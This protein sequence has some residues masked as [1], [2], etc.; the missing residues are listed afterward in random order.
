MRIV[1]PGTI[2]E[3]SLLTPKKTNYLCSVDANHS[4]KNSSISHVSIAWVDIS[5]SQCHF[6]TIPCGSLESELSRLAPTEILIS[7][8]LFSIPKVKSHVGSFMDC[9]STRAASMFNTKKCEEIIKTFFSTTNTTTLGEITDSE[10]KAIGSLIEYLSHTHK[11]SLPKLS[12][13]RRVSADHFMNIDASTRSSLELTKNLAGNN[14]H[15]LLSAIDTT[16]TAAGGRLLLSHIT[17]PLCN[18]EAINNRLDALEFFIQHGELRKKV[19]ELLKEFTDIERAVARVCIFK[20]TLK[21][22]DTIR[23]GLRSANK[24]ISI[25]TNDN[26]DYMPSNLKAAILQ[27]TTPTQVMEQLTKALA[28]ELP[29]HVK[30]GDFVRRKFSSELDRLYDIKMN[31]DNKVESLCHKYKSVSGISNLKINHN[32]VIGYYIEVKPNMAE[33][34]DESVFIHRQTLGTSMRFVSDELKNLE[35]E[36]IKC[37]DNISNLENEIFHT[38]CSRV[39][40]ESSSIQI[41]SLGVASIDLSTSLAELAVRSNYFRP[42]VDDS[43][44][45]RVVGGRHPVVE[46][47]IN[48]E[49]ISNNCELHDSS[50]LWIITGPNMAGKSTFLR[51]NALIAIMAQIGSFVPATNAHIGVIDRLF[52]RIGASDNIS[53]GES[54]FMVE[55]L[56][57]SYIIN[58]ATDRSFVILDEIGR[59]TSTYDGLAIASSVLEHLHNRIRCR[60]LFATHYHELTSMEEN[61]GRVSC[62][63]MSIEEWN[64]K[65]IFL[66]RII[67][68]KA[69]K[70]YGIHVAQLAGI[71]AAVIE[72]ANHILTTLEN[73]SNDVEICHT[74][75]I[76]R[77][78]INEN[79][80]SQMH[81]G[82]IEKVKEVIDGVEI[83]DITPRNALDILCRLK[84]LV[85]K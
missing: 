52:S 1:T 15:T 82:V 11:S 72:R 14:K 3:D 85:K 2:V 40:E 51:Q 32:N 48:D 45:F 17:S 50:N 84:Q 74:D 68:G 81:D 37:N 71:P 42:K 69:D 65:I 9:I 47:N 41:I 29:V 19:R 7:D 61:L 13:P 30:D 10:I 38:L 12:H 33:K 49:F 73:S 8:S 5:T 55:M 34:L 20:G 80:S 58:H 6:T 53:Q 46:K 27:V 22:L 63:T 24:I 36:I 31:A 44:E 79:G 75:I 59:G 67:R 25:I 21:D 78:G 70:S 77:Q 54:T 35:A 16:L 28:I 39:I 64:D 76:S 56:E 18:P 26:Y 83:N 62:H 4:P 60:T 23:K 66:H 57:T 43:K